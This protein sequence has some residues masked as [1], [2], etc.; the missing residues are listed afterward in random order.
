MPRILSNPTVIINNANITV[1]PNSVMYTEGLGEQSIKVASAGGGSVEL[2]SSENV[3]DRYSKVSLS[4]PVTEDNIANALTWKNN[5]NNNVIAITSQGFTR[6]FGEA[7]LITDYEVN[8]QSDG[9]IDLEFH[10]RAAV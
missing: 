9:Q 7:T 3:E 8:M 4:I 1:M 6:T 5:E 2:L 10:T